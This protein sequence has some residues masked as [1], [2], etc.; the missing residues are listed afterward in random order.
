MA[1]PGGKEKPGRERRSASSFNKAS[2]SS[3]TPSATCALTSLQVRELSEER[4]GRR[5]S[6]PENFWTFSNSAIGR[7]KVSAP[8]NSSERQSTVPNPGF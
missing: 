6:A 8:R 2:A 7:Y 4:R 1:F 5:P 3:R